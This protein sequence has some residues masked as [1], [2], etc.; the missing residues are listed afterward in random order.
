MNSTSVKPNGYFLSL[1]TGSNSIINIKLNDGGDIDITKQQTT[2]I[3]FWI[4]FKGIINPS[5]SKCPIIMRFSQVTDSFLCIDNTST[6]FFYHLT[7]DVVYKQDG[8]DKYMGQWV[9]FSISNY[10]SDNFVYFPNMMLLYLQ[11]EQVTREVTYEVP[12]PGLNIDN[13]DI[14]NEIAALITDLRFYNNYIIR[15]YG[16]VMGRYF[17]Y[18]EDLVLERKLRGTSP[19]NCLLNAD[20]ISGDVSGLKYTCVADYH[21]Y[22]DSTTRCLSDN[23]YFN[24]TNIDNYCQ[25]ECDSSCTNSNLPCA[26]KSNLGCSCAFNGSQWLRRD[27]STDSVYC[28]NLPYLDFAK[29][30]TTTLDNVKVASDGDYS[31]EFWFY[32]Y[33]YNQTIS[34]FSSYELIWDKMLKA[35]IYDKNNTLTMRCY[36]IYDSSDPNAFSD[37]SEDSLTLKYYQWNYVQCSTSL[38]NKKYYIN[39]NPETN[40]QQIIPSGF[41]NFTNITSTN[42]IM[43]PSGHTNYGFLFIREIKLWAIYNIREFFTKCTVG[44]P[45]YVENLLHYLPL[46]NNSTTITDSVEGIST[47]SIPSTDWIGYNVVDF[48]NVLSIEDIPF[49]LNNCPYLTIV[50]TSGYIATTKFLVKC[51][52]PNNNNYTYHYYYTLSH[53]TNSTQYTILND[54]TQSETTFSIDSNLNDDETSINIF[55]DVNANGTTVT[56]FSRLQLY[57][58]SAINDINFTNVTDSFDL[59]NDYSDDELL[60]RAKTL[61]SLVSNINQ[62]SMQNMTQVKPTADNSTIVIQDP[63]CN[64]NYCNQQGDCYLIDKFIACSCKPGYLGINCQVSEQNLEYLKTSYYLLWNQ[65]TYGNNFTTLSVNIT[66]TRV[67]AINT[68][69]SGASKFFPDDYFFTQYYNFLRYLTTYAQEI[70]IGSYELLFESLN[71]IILYNIDKVNKYKI[72]SMSGTFKRDVQVSVMQRQQ[73]I[74]AFTYVRTSIKGL[75][76]QFINAVTNTGQTEAIN[77]NFFSYHINI[78]KIDNPLKFDFNSY[79]QPQRANYD[80]YFDASQCMNTIQYSKAIANSF[81]FSELSNGVFQDIPGFK[82]K[83][84]EIYS[85]SIY[86]KINPYIYDNSYHERASFLHSIYFTDNNGNILDVKDCEKPI[87]IYSPVYIYNSTIISYLNAN[88]TLFNPDAQYGPTDPIF[89]NPYYIDAN[90][91]VSNQTQQERIDKYHRFYNFTCQFYDVTK[92]GYSPVGM[93]YANFTHDNFIVCNTTHLTD[94]QPQYVYNPPDYP[95]D[96]PFYYIGSPRIFLCSCNY[97]TNLCFFLI[98]FVLV[99]Y[100]VSLIISLVFDIPYF[101]KESLINHIKLEI[102]KDQKPY[103]TEDQYENALKKFTKIIPGEIPKTNLDKNNNENNNVMKLRDNQLDN[104]DSIHVSGSNK[105]NNIGGNVDLVINNFMLTDLNP[106]HDSYKEDCFENELTP[107]QL[108]KYNLKHRHIYFSAYYARSSFNP[109]Y[110]KITLL[111]TQLSIM[112]M[113]NAIFF[114]IDTGVNIVNIY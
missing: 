114:T 7:S 30:N 36:P 5:A 111:F 13:I 95:T 80:G 58:N 22:L 45:K 29:T 81:N 74:N 76:N 85:V 6:L 34:G 67:E 8:F 90:G 98:L 102:L 103:L 104:L 61:S 47:S 91:T 14:G 83:T 60:N 62:Q 19:S 35:S 97:F 41:G 96:G 52:P 17:T 28:D 107:W 66:S 109:R 11:A 33:S 86:Y 87:Q 57:L 3:T 69:I 49:T 73:V 32:L 40:I 27:N 10:Y 110:K 101:R 93:Q 92:S 16:R 55:C 72:Q 65:L 68:V 21:P 18:M 20:V 43:Q 12:G 105:E 59:Y 23:N 71:D 106:N 89:T 94:F 37:Y 108:L 53:S 84:N 100:I 112:L 75:A 113:F 51:M 70:I 4:K 48:N 64:D 9:F 25:G 77:L 54:T 44:I 88:K 79:F 24:I 82:P 31:L 50:P 63:V 46:A 78:K 56:A 39:T 42:F 26:T 1:P 99:I 15:P 38:K 2:T